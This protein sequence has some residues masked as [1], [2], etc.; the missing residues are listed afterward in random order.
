MTWAAANVVWSGETITLLELVKQI[1]C[2]TDESRDDDYTWYL[3][4]AGT[5]AEQYCNTALYARNVVDNFP[6]A[7]S[8]VPLSNWPASA[9]VLVE[10]DGE[11][12]TTDW[13]TFVDNGILWAT[14]NRAGTTTP[15]RFHQLAITYT[16]G[17]D[18]L[19]ADLAN[20]IA[21]QALQI[22]EQTTGPV[23]KETV[24]GV[25]SIEYLV[26]DYSGGPFSPAYSA[27][28]NKYRRFNA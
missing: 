11:D 19:P 27:I 3:E 7:I 25:G 10:L 16:A 5:A 18:P 23:K 13:E 21:R 9:L 20:V 15:T 24:V 2:V 1:A 4:A 28:L 8:P 6:N 26:D 12:V 22:S 17:F 14:N